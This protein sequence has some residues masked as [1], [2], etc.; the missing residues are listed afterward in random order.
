MF[1]ARPA[2]RGQSNSPSDRKV[3]F[4]QR[5]AIRLLTPSSS[6]YFRC[7]GF[8]WFYLCVA[9]WIQ[10]CRRNAVQGHRDVRQRVPGTTSRCRGQERAHRIAQNAGGEV[11]VNLGS[12]EVETKRGVDIPFIAV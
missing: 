11:H 10:D 2:S 12:C 9:A 1:R 8:R 4:L 6:L 5:L 7:A 3:H